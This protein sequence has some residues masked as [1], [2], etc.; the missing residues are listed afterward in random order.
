MT[1]KL[2]DLEGRLDAAMN[3]G[4]KVTL[5]EAMHLVEGLSASLIM[6]SNQKK[7]AVSALKNV[8]FYA[9]INHGDKARDY[10]E[11]VDPVLVMLGVVT[12]E[13]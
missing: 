7:V 11:I 8:S 9:R 4:D 6:V 3:R 5:R 10:G 2:T 12:G 1:K 13:L